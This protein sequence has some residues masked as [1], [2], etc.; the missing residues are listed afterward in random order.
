MLDLTLFI[1]DVNGKNVQR[2]T[3][4]I[5]S[6]DEPSWSPDGT[7]IVYVSERDGSKALYIIKATG[8]KPRQLT[9]HL[10]QDFSPAWAPTIFSVAPSSNTRLMP[11]SALK[12]ITLK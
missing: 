4:D 9:E 1:V 6:N 7:S 5:H 12:R 8:G 3:N 10:G 11:W 2:L